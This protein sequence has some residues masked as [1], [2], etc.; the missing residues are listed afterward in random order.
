MRFSSLNP[1]SSPFDSS[2]DEEMGEATDPFVTS[3]SAPTVDFSDFDSDVQGNS[4]CRSLSESFGSMPFGNSAGGFTA[5]GFPGDQQGPPAA[6]TAF[7]NFCPPTFTS[8]GPAS[9]GDLRMTAARS[10]S[11]LPRIDPPRPVAI[12]TGSVS[13]PFP[14][15]QT[16]EDCAKTP[17]ASP[18]SSYLMDLDAMDESSQSN[19]FSHTG[20]VSSG[21]DGGLSLA[22]PTRSN[23]IGST[24]PSRFIEGSITFRGGNRPPTPDKMAPPPPV[25]TRSQQIQEQDPRL[26]QMRQLQ[27]MQRKLRQQQIEQQD[28]S[29]H[30]PPRPEYRR[31]DG[32]T[33]TPKK[34]PRLKRKDD[35]EVSELFRSQSMPTTELEFQFNREETHDPLP[36]LPKSSSARAISSE[37]LV[38]LM[39]GHFKEQIEGY[40]IIDCRFPYEFKGGHIKGAHNVPPSDSMDKLTEMFMERAN[41]L[42]SK[43][44]AIVF[45]CEFSSKRGPSAY[46]LLR[47][48][49]RTANI[50]RYPKM[51]FPHMYI[52]EG[53]YKEFFSQ[54]P[55]YC[56]PQCYVTMKDKKYS[57]ELKLNT[58]LKRISERQRS[59]SCSNFNLASLRESIGRTR[60]TSREPPQR[61]LSQS[62]QVGIQRT[63]SRTLRPLAESQRYC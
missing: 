34:K 24:S 28:M 48:M 6:T 25:R 32:S 21:M 47:G 30:K 2:S 13:I 1:E 23:T 62:Q 33:L 18:A 43:K 7:R 50:E 53:G 15:D 41:L 42:A 54:Y 61:M 55:Q 17:P 46:K 19:D 11:A 8:F 56:Y 9:I 52:L 58:R 12:R 27:E 44:L 14:V 5:S 38:R 20:M 31:G 35:E 63:R 4:L 59:L 57:K 45:H 37:T 16:M 10:S 26:E 51:Y 39:E 36:T 22:L 49:D 29:P 3:T 40:Y 60:S